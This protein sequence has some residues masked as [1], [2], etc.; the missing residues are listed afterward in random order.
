MAYNPVVDEV[1][2]SSTALGLLVRDT[3]LAGTV[4]RDPVPVDQFARKKNDTV[5]IYLP[6]YAVANKRSLRANAARVRST[7]KER[8]VDVLLENDLQVDVPLTDENITLDVENLARQVIAPSMGAIVRAYDEEIATLMEGATYEDPVTWDGDSDTDGPY[9]SLVEARIKLDDMSV[10]STERFLVVGSTLAAD[11]LTSKLLVQAN[12]AGSTSTLRSG[13]IGE[14]ASFTVMTSPFL[15]PDF[16]VAY[17]RTA[18][19]LASR[20]PAVPDGVAWGNVQASNGFAVRVMQHLSQDDDK[21]LLNIVY[22]D[23]WFGASVVT[24]NGHI[25][26]NGKF[27]PS[28]DPE[29]VSEDDLFVRAVALDGSGS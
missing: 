13:V 21:D 3:M 28:T 8:K 4:W 15:S 17:H 7:L 19:A 29:G 12:T 1:A 9:K 6:A 18:F 10:P 2:I 16:G 20:A 23:S 27:I 25:D 5:S 24:D 22:H 26:S 11:L 14:V